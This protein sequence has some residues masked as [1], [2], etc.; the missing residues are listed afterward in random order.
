M[1]SQFRYGIIKNNKKKNTFIM[2][3]NNRT[4]K[5]DSKDDFLYLK[6]LT[7]KGHLSSEE[8]DKVIAYMRPLMINPADRN[9]FNPDNYKFYFNKLL[10]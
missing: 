3:D 10:T 6:A 4:I 9:I 5:Y 8:I 7:I 2:I 1:A